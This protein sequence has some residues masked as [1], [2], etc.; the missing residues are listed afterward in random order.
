MIGQHFSTRTGIRYRLRHGNAAGLL[1]ANAPLMN[2]CGSLLI[3]SN[4]CLSRLRTVS[5]HFSAVACGLQDKPFIPPCRPDA[6]YRHNLHQRIAARQPRHRSSIVA[7]SA[8]VNGAIGVAIPFADQ[9]ISQ[10][11][12]AKTPEAQASIAQR[13]PIYRRDQHDTHPR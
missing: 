8:S 3:L 7:A 11:V 13:A 5:V 12:S 6:T 2:G 1:P 4:G 9:R 10:P